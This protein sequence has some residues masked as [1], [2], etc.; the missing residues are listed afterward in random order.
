MDHNPLLLT[1][2][3]SRSIKSNMF[4]FQAAWISHPDYEPLVDNTW[5]NS[6]GSAA[7]KLTQVRAQSI[8]FNRETF[9]IYLKIRGYWKLELEVFTRN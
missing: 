5:K 8:T 1:C 4:H 6:A 2:S 7:V 3:E 9:G